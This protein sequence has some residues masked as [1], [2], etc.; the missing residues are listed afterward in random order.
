MQTILV[1]RRAA[2]RRPFTQALMLISVLLCVAATPA[3][4]WAQDK[5]PRVGI[6]AQPQARSLKLYQVFE[7]ILR[8]RG[9]TP[10]KN[11]VLEYRSPDTEQLD[12]RKSA[13]D[14]VR[15]KVDVIYAG[16]APA[17]RAAFAATR[18]I[19]IVA[20]DYTNDPVAAGYAK[21]YN[22]PGLNVTGVFLDAPEFTSKW[23]EILKLLKP[24]LSRVAVLWDPSPGA[25]HLRGLESA[26]KALAVELEVIKI[27][28]PED[29]NRTIAALGEA[30]AQALIELPSPLMFGQSAR[31]G[32]LVRQRGLLAISMWRRFAEG[33]G[34]VSYGPDF[35]ESGERAALILAKILSGAKPGDL[36]IERPNKF[37]FI[38]NQKTI[39]EL[40]LS[41]PDSLLQRADE[42]IR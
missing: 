6:L 42:L 2:M 16:S 15:Q 12:F 17:L 30:R 31:V 41:V 28:T 18:S 38:I 39:K 8:E 23:L 37:E 27:Q 24:G 1:R 33:G 35:D 32:A 9:W 3:R 19:P 29:I 13:E 36:P 7:R 11:I 26:A 34:A 20:L 5:I 25:T 14:L 21:S 22:R 4:S 10:G 40:G